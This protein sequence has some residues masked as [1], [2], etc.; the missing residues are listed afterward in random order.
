MSRRAALLCA[1]LG[2]LVWLAAAGSPWQKPADPPPADAAVPKETAAAKDATPPKPTGF[3]NTGESL[4]YSLNW[5]TGASLGEAHLRA[6]KNDDSWDFDFSLDASVPGFGISD[7]YHSRANADM[8][9]LQLEKTTTH[10]P[11]NTHEKTVFDYH[12]GSATRTTL[13]PGGG[14]TDISIGNC[15]H[16]GLDYVF[17]ARREL[18]AG[19]GVPQEQDVLFG[20][21]YSVR[22]EYAGV[23]DVTLGGKHHQA[24]HVNVYV[25]GPVADSKLEIFFA[26]DTART[27]L[28]IKAPLPVGTLSMELVR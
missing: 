5:P 12:E 1:L 19:H 22:M 23:Q 7:H 28:I 26:R 10:G 8:C 18:G 2:F 14:H 16:D 17:Y 13:G 4:T 9:S 15:A 24:D 11:K 27:P 3:P 6:G 21:S 25:K 20:A